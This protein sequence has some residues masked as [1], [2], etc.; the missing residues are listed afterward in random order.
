MRIL[1]KSTAT[2]VKHFEGKNGKPDREIFEQQAA[3]DVG[4]E[5]PLP[6]WVAVDPAKPYPPGLYDFD[7]TSFRTTPYGGIE[8]NNYGVRLVVLVADKAKAVA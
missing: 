2:R 6:F 5:F 4:G 7:P 3:L 8:L 1:V